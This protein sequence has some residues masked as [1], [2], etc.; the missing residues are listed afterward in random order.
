LAWWSVSF[1]LYY[2]A[3]R[4]TFGDA[5]F[6]WACAY[7]IESLICSETLTNR[8]LIHEVDLGRGFG[9]ISSETCEVPLEGAMTNDADEPDQAQDPTSE[10]ESTG[11]SG[12]T[13]IAVLTL[14]VSLMM[15]SVLF[16]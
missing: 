16:W 1:L 6:P 14:L 11:N 2:P 9:S 7:G 12:C 4:L 13:T 3:K 8:T 5:I 10:N 15:M